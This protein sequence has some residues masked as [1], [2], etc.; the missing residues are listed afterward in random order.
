MQYS[1]HGNTLKLIRYRIDWSEAYTHWDEEQECDVSETRNITRFA[2]S[3][4]EMKL[5]VQNHPNAVVVQIN[6]P[7]QEWMDGLEFTQKQKESGEI[8]RAESMGE[9]AYKEYLAA[10]DR[11][12]QILDL[13]YRMS[14]LELGITGGALS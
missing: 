6:Q 4:S 14:C 10:V 13:D 9:T 3:E 12:Q 8:E 7:N 5:I 11:D 1:F 2:A